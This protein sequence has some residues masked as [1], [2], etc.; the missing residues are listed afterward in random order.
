MKKNT[1]YSFLRKALKKPQSFILAI[2]FIFMGYEASFAQDFNNGSFNG[3]RGENVVASGWSKFG[4]DGTNSPDLNQPGTFLYTTNWQYN[5]FSWAT[6]PIASP[7]GGN[8]Q[9]F[10]AHLEGIQQTVNGLV[11][12]HT[13]RLTFHYAVMPIKHYENGNLHYDALGAPKF[14]ISG[15]PWMSPPTLPANEWGTHTYDFVASGTSALFVFQG[16]QAKSYVAID[17]AKLTDLSANSD[18]QVEK[19]VHKINNGPILDATTA[20]VNVGDQIEFVIVAK[21]N[22]PIDVTDVTV[23]D[24]L[25]SGYTYVSHSSIDG[26][27]NPTTGVWDVIPPGGTGPDLPNGF[28][29][30]LFIK[31]I[32]KATGDYANIATI[33]HPKD[34]T[35]NNNSSSPTVT[36]LTADVEMI[37][38]LHRI[39]GG[40]IINTNTTPYPTANVGDQ[41]EFEIMVKNNGSVDV[42]D[43]IVN[44]PLP[45]GYTYVSHTTGDG[46]YNPTTGVWD[47]APPGGTGPDLP[48]G[49]TRFLYIRATVKATGNHTNTATLQHIYNDNT[50]NNNSSSAG[51]TALTADLQVEKLVHRINEGSIL[52]VNSANVSPGDQIEFVIVAKNNGPIDITDVTV[53]DI[54]PDGY[55]YVSY[56]SIDGNYD[57]T[58][59]VWDVIPPGGTGPDLPNGSSRYLFIKAIVKT[60]GN[61]ANIATINHPSDNTPNNNSSSPTVTVSSASA[62]VEMRKY[63]HKINDGPVINTNTTPYPTV[64]VGDEVK[65]E[66][67]VENYGPGSVTDVKV[68][69]LLPNGYTYV[70]HTTTHGSYTPATGVWDV[71]PAGLLGPDVPS[72][73]TRFLYITATVNA[74]GNH[75]NTAT[76]EPIPNDNT[77]NNNTSSAGV[78]VTAPVGGCTAGCNS[79]AYLNSTN[80]FATIEYDNMVSAFHGTLARE[81]DGKFYAWGEKAHNNGSDDLHYKTEINQANYP[82]LTG[83]V[84]KIAAGSEGEEQDQYAV[85]TTDGLFVWGTPD[86]LISNGIKNNRPFARVSIGTYGVNGGAG[87]A[88]GLPNGVNPADVKMLF[89]T[90]EGLAIV[91]CD[92]QGWVLTTHGLAY[93]DGASDNNSNDRVWHRVSTASNTPL[94]NIVVIRGTYK[95]FVAITSNGNVYTWGNNTYLGNGS[96]QTD[97]SFATEMERPNLNGVSVKMIGMSNHD[98]NGGRTYYLLG[99]NSRLYTL[100]E[101]G[102]K[103]LGTG[104]NND[105]DSYNWV[106]VVSTI[107]PNVAWISP[108]EHDRHFGAINILTKD[109][110]QWAWGSTDTQMIGVDMNAVGGET[111]PVFMPGGLNHSD[112]I[113]AVET[114]G[115]TTINVKACSERIGYVGHWV[116]GSMGNGYGTGD[117]VVNYNYTDTP[118]MNIC[119]AEPSLACDADVEMIKYLHRINGGSVINT[120]TIPYPTVNVGDQVEF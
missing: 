78:T 21:N 31:A 90:N 39:N 117:V 89:G 115:H 119:G 32:V 51:V 17:G 101:N 19:L 105:N 37:K 10:A 23:N 26:S 114:G 9:N 11:S 14:A 113:I 33:N 67:Q 73:V 118:V 76:L 55:T 46:S 27:Y 38:Y 43:V 110:K 44:D 62:N 8:F 103:Q 25:P 12:G 29:R 69:D 7:D 111:N 5:S 57:P 68:N 75:T 48:N 77:P 72:G 96:G 3:T 28:S 94:E 45:N 85:L 100:G 107:G 82:S 13:Y 86:A 52:D 120:N 53:N 84:L 42:A 15:G 35:P 60:T 40:P 80:D 74:T 20:T 108:Q 61:Y 71:A 4:T 79:N 109:G 58:T 59:G 54:L 83:T 22:G 70:S 63:L 66:I 88:D 91:T 104:G 97:R 30:Y 87:K 99:T 102:V 16:Q 49:Y 64:N 65:F 1:H 116:R 24:L 92:G 81:A 95:A 98:D 34:N 6:A 93:G 36:V 56:S 18:L 41:V 50:P 47:V 2:V 112:K 106:E